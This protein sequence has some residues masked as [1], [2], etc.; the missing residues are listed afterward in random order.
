MDARGKK[1]FVSVNRNMGLSTDHAD[2]DLLDSI[3][4]DLKEV[5]SE[6]EKNVAKKVNEKRLRTTARQRHY[7]RMG[8]EGQSNWAMIKTFVILLVCFIQYKLVT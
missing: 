5:I 1:L 4:D 8:M 7:L 6:I 3:A 2:A